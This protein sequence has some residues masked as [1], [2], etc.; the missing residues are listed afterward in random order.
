MATILKQFEQSCD[1]MDDRTKVNLINHVPFS[2][3]WAEVDPVAYRCALADFQPVCE[4]CGREFWPD[5]SADEEAVCQ[6]ETC[7]REAGERS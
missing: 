4:W 3:V 1:E 2:R 5:S 6:D 7:Q